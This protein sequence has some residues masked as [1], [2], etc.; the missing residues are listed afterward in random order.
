MYEKFGGFEGFKKFEGFAVR[1]I[2]N[3]LKLYPT[4]KVN[5]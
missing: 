1:N 5:S 4:G 2:S 3:S